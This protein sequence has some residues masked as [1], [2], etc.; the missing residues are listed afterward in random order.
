[1]SR[2]RIL[3]DKKVTTGLFLANISL[4]SFYIQD[5]QLYYTRGA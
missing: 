4:K 1:M 3:I 2:E 5:K